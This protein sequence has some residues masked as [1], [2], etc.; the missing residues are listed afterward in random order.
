M[1][2]DSTRLPPLLAGGFQDKL[3]NPLPAMALSVRG[4]DGTEIG[5]SQLAFPSESTAAQNV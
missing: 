4:A 1:L 3:T 2:Y 5:V